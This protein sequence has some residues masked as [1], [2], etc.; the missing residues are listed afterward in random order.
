M[1][2]TALTAGIAMAD[3]TPPLEAGLLTSSVN[4]AWA[5]F[6]SVRMPLKARVV[7]LGEGAGRL[8]LV[9]LDLL[10]LH[11]TAVGGWD[12]FKRSLSDT[13]PPERIILTCTHTHTAPESVALTD[14]YKTAPFLAWLEQLKNGIAAA[15]REA[16][17]RTA[18]CTLHY[19]TA[20]LEGYSLQRRIPTAAGII[21][22]DSM[23]PISPELMAR[24]PVDRRVRALWLR[25]ADGAAIATIV[26]AVCHPVHEMCLPQVSPDFPGELC[27]ALDATP[28]FGMCLYLNGAAG[29]INPATVSCGAE[30]ARQHGQ[31]LAAAVKETAPRAETVEASSFTYA[32]REV[33]LP[34]RSLT[35]TSIRETCTARISSIRLG[36]LAVVFLPAEPFVETGLEIERTSPFNY[37]LVVGYAENSVG[38]MP[39]EQ[40]FR[41]GGYE[42]GPGKWSFLQAGADMIVREAAGEVLDRLNRD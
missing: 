42:A 29:D 39:P 12:A 24:E 7:V 17:A 8:A 5:P 27:A 2:P 34:M 23:Q 6:E 3:I 32:H 11:D 9:A 13:I 35:G 31:A 14:L 26:H 15:I 10:A 40:A 22:S 1:G 38:Y 25:A 37:T 36:R 21:M 30:T 20:V 4:G 18:P 33:Q 19:G 28:G 16:A 41:D